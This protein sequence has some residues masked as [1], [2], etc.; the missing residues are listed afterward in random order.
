MGLN[1]FSLLE[2]K[3]YDVWWKYPVEK[4]DAVWIFLVSD[5]SWS[6]I[7]AQ[8]DPA[9]SS[10]IYAMDI[11][12]PDSLV[13]II[14]SNEGPSHD[15]VVLVPAVISSTWWYDP[16]AATN[17][18]QPS[19]TFTCPEGYEGAWKQFTTIA[20]YQVAASPVADYVIFP[21]Q[22]SDEITWESTMSIHKKSI[23]DN[24]ISDGTVLSAYPA[25]YPAFSVDWSKI[26]YKYDRSVL[27]YDPEDPNY[28]VSDPNSWKIFIKSS[29]DNGNWT[30]FINWS[31][32][33]P[34][35]SPD[36]T[37]IVYRNSDDDGK[38]Y[39][40]L[41]SDTNPEN[42]WVLLTTWKWD[43]PFFANIWWT[44]YIIYTHSTDYT[45]INPDTQEEETYNRD[46]LY[47]MK[48]DLSDGDW[49]KITQNWWNRWTISPDWNW[50]I[51]NDR[52]EADSDKE[53]IF[54]KSA[55]DNLDWTPITPTWWYRPAYSRDWNWIFYNGPNDELYKKCAD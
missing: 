18:E 13:A 15:L 45:G 43:H 54:K 50:I 33:A 16:N 23:T 20:A 41:I 25:R 34:A 35:F 38:L 46:E 48:A 53:K 9:Y 11:N 17:P 44:L 29:A 24:T 26:A 19:W 10:W 3:A 22:Q 42:K 47:K 36:W 30:E 49:V 55:A 39:K 7:P 1:P 12:N 51:Y 14:D 27:S 8:E 28:Y 37:Y 31:N 52:D 4:W 6:Y 32:D 21:N 40:K 2:T 5:W